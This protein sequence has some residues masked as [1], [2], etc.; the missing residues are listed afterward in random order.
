M[1]T[2]IKYETEYKGIKYYHEIEIASG[3]DYAYFKA[4]FDALLD[5]GY[6]FSIVV[7]K[8]KT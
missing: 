7:E 6:N 8:E 2:K 4:L 5:R 3:V 1:V